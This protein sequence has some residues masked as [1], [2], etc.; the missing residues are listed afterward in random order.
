[1]AVEILAECL[2]PVVNREGRVLE[3]FPETIHV[4]S[5]AEG[6]KIFRYVLD[7]L[8][9]EGGTRTS[10]K[11]VT[12]ARGWGFGRVV[13]I[14]KVCPQCFVIEDVLGFVVVPLGTEDGVLVGAC[15]IV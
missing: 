1:M 8:C 9:F 2:S 4:W 7:I 12:S 14:A 3:R 5:E 15:L 10:G 13:G 6:V 11:F